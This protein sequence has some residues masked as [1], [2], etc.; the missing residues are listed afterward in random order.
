[1]LFGSSGVRRPYDLPFAELAMALG[2]ALAAD[3]EEVVV[4]MDTRTSSP[5]L[6][7]A[8]IAGLLSAGARVSLGGIAPSPTVAF[9]ARRFDRGLMVTASHNPEEYNGLKVFNPDGSSLT[10]PQQEE[11]G[12]RMAAAPARKGWECQGS[13]EEADLVAGHRD[14][15]L[16]SRK[17][18]RA[19][20]AVVDCGNG[21]GSVIAP[22][23]LAAMGVETLPL[24]CHTGGHFAR[25]S[26]P[27]E[28]GLGYVGELVRAGPADCGVVHDGDA[29]RMM[30]FDGR[31]RFIDGDRLMVLFARY[32]GAKRVVTTMDASMIID[33]EAEVQRTPVGDTYVSTRLREWGDF[34]GEPSGAWIFPGHSLCP[35]G[36]YAAALFC[37]MASEWQIAEELDKIPRYPIVRESHPCGD[38]GGVL[39]RLGAASPTDG[40]RSE[41]EDGWFLIRA[42]GTEPKVRITAE[43]KTAAA[44][45]RLAS[46]GRAMLGR[47]K[48][49]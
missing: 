7:D 39:T 14:A 9:A 32:L 36:I 5:I 19:L 22:Q 11:V 46:K 40:I 42:S 43:G 17:V 12:Q 44:A 27:S 41:E 21:A 3:A 24:N 38:A 18:G 47:A 37:E 6:A 20:V 16:S 15:I 4:G 2:S 1:M 10:P 8:A 30:G 28:E 25:P 35:D 33:G 45:K 49:A 31:G 23:T 26:E 34:G 13:L 29:D 48:R